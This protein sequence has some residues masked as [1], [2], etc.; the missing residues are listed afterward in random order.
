M[1][2]CLNISQEELKDYTDLDINLFEINRD[3]LQYGVLR[4][5]RA[6][7]YKLDLIND[8]TNDKYYEF[9]SQRDTFKDEAKSFDNRTAENWL[10]QLSKSMNVEAQVITEEV[11][12][13]IHADK[14]K[15]YSGENAFFADGI[16]YFIEGK[17]TPESVVHEFS[18]PIIKSLPKEIRDKLYNELLADGSFQD[19]ID[20]VNEMYQDAPESIQEEVLVRALT[21][22]VEMEELSPKLKNWF[23][24]LMY[25]IK[26]ILRKLLGRKVNVG[27]LQA[28]TTLKGLAEM[29]AKGDVLELQKEMITSS[30][31]IEYFKDKE[32]FIESFDTISP[33]NKKEMGI[34]FGT[35]GKIFSAVAEQ[36]A[37]ILNSEKAGDIML[38]LNGIFAD[39]LEFRYMQ[40]IEALKEKNPSLSKNE[41]IEYFSKKDDGTF[42]ELNDV[43]HERMGNMMHALYK[44]N[45]ILTEGNKK[46]KAIDKLNSREKLDR[47]IYFKRHMLN[48]QEVI[49]DF[50]RIGS[51]EEAYVI[52]DGK[53]KL[54]AQGEPIR[55]PVSKLSQDLK[56]NLTEMQ[57]EIAR[58]Q[59]ESV[60]DIFV[61][62]TAP[63]AKDALD[64]F[65]AEMDGPK[66]GAPQKIRDA[67]YKRF[68]SMTE[69]EYKQYKEL[70]AKG[71][72]SD[73]YNRLH[74]LWLTGL[75]F[76]ESKADAI[77]DG[78]AQDANWSN[79]FLES[80]S[81]NT[82]PAIESVYKHIQMMTNM[83][84]TNAQSWMANFITVV[85]PNIH[86]FSGQKRGGIGLKQSFRDRIATI[87]NGAI[88]EREEI[89]FLN[90][91][92]N[93]RY[94]QT[95][96][97]HKIEEAKKAFDADG[98]DASKKLW[99]EAKHDYQKWKNVYMNQDFDAGYYAANDL[100]MKDDIGYEA[101]ERR[102]AIFDEM[103]KLQEDNSDG[104]HNEIIDGLKHDLKQ[105][106][107]TTDLFGNKKTGMDLAV[108]ERL[109]EYTQA[110]A[111]YFI[112]DEIPGAFQDAYDEYSEYVIANGSKMGEPAYNEKM[113]E[114]LDRNTRT[115]L[116]NSVYT[117]REKLIAEKEELLKLLNEE[118]K[119]IFDDTQEQ[120]LIN[121]QSNQ[122][123]D[124]GNQPDG[125]EATAKSR[126]AVLDA[127]IEVEKKRQDMITRS[128]LSKANKARF[129]ELRQIYNDDG[130]VWKDNSNEQEYNKLVKEKTETSERLGLNSVT[131]AR[132]SEIDAILSQDNIPT[133]YYKNTI[134]TL[135][136][137][138]KLRTLFQEF[139]ENQGHEFTSMEEAY[140]NDFT[141]FVQSAQGQ[142]AVKTDD[143]FK[144]FVEQNHYEKDGVLTPTKL[145]L[146]NMSKNPYDYRTKRLMSPKDKDGNR[147][148]LDLIKIDDQYRI[149]SAEFFTRV[150]KEKYET[151]KVIGETVDNR[152]KWL[153]KEEPGNTY[154]NEK[155]Y[156]LKENDPKTFEFMENV[157]REYIKG[158]EVGE[159]NDKMW[160]TFPRTRKTR[161][162][163][164]VT[165]NVMKFTRRTREAFM[166]AED[167]VFDYKGN[168]ET[169]DELKQ[170]SEHLKSYSLINTGVKMPVIG[171][172]EN[173]RGE[174]MHIDDVS[175]D[176][177]KTIPEYIASL[178]HKK[179][180]KEANSYARMMQDEVGKVEIDKR[181]FITQ[182]KSNRK[183]DSNYD[184]LDESYVKH[185][186]KEG[187]SKRD[188]IL[189][190]LI[191]RDLD[192]ITLTGT[193]SQARLVHRAL[194]SMVK[195][196]SKMNFNWNLSSG[197]INFGQMKITSL[198]HVLAGQEMSYKNYVLGEKWATQTA[199]KV[200]R[201]IR[202]KGHK[203]LDEQIFTLFDAISGRAMETM[204]DQL[205]RTYIGDVLDNK[206]P[207]KVRKWLEM[208]GALQNFGGMM[209][210]KKVKITDSAGNTKEIPY[211]K[212]FELVDGR[213]QTKEGVEENYAVTYDKDGNP[214][215]GEGFTEQKL[216]MQNVIMKWN[217]AFAKKD[218]ALVGRWVIAKQLLFL[219]KHVI[220]IA[221]KQFSFGL[222]MSR[223][224]WLPSM[225]KRMNWS[226]GEAEW[227]HWVGTA[228]V[229]R[230]F[231]A[232]AAKGQN[233]LMYLSKS[234]LKGM[235]YVAFQ[236]LIGY[237][238][239]S[240]WRLLTPHFTDDDGIEKTDFMAMHDRSGWY[241]EGL[242]G[243]YDQDGDPETQEG[244]GLYADQDYHDF[245]FKGFML[246]H[247]SMVTA[248]LNDEYN[249]VNWL[250]SWSGVKD[251][252]G[253]TTSQSIALSQVFDYGT[254]LIDM[255]S[256]ESPTS[257]SQ[258][259]GPYFFEQPDYKYES[260]FG[261]IGGNY[262]RWM[263]RFHGFNNK[264]L[265]PTGA[266]ERFEAGKRMR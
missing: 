79:G 194:D 251:V 247:L 170:D 136:N 83:Y 246:N 94:D 237:L 142:E 93:Y 77:L 74:E 164:V 128:G 242:F 230:D 139:I 224:S 257:P 31:V 52:E 68:H 19:I 22:L 147:K 185:K 51:R 78:S 100:L 245:H 181:N 55:N 148:K 219:K 134:I 192:G 227:G 84:E 54:D 85:S 43:I 166:G 221:S 80:L 167:D 231:F 65:N 116:K 265:N 225:R 202:R 137:T 122:V 159:N 49:N 9:N 40:E 208:Q 46:V 103:N 156:Q 27:K 162:E 138:P 104:R 28:D 151:K 203:S 120:T 96:H 115:V 14:Q 168:D 112:E 238:L 233:S 89:V 158:Q 130:G 23:D 121:E 177:L 11:A 59:K 101:G 90:P 29:V 205:S 30:D 176:F 183:Q 174:R 204:G 102:E 61:E 98:T 195:R 210:E 261:D 260:P 239:K 149:P 33:N 2:S 82:D 60:R 67:A 91:W 37:D 39:E 113:A 173:A 232:S 182:Q 97:K 45:D 235:G 141:A 187:R 145:W 124:N 190:A 76:D 117:Q 241:D 63:M 129:D 263:F 186:R 36:K 20:D 264:M 150:V 146:V 32:K 3:F 38:S 42:T 160:L 223:H 12:E 244:L 201:D 220:P 133:D 88:V 87:E 226:T 206:N 48:Y 50:N 248:K 5:P 34:M 15:K 252:I 35:M 8:E 152:G 175:T 255:M 26:Q 73:D 189:E 218:Q 92:K 7:R 198:T 258:V 193:G 106:R 155:Y 105:L 254:S 179:G 47:L 214:S 125:N 215:L 144:K 171:V 131:L 110:R 95:V 169:R 240:L 114:W 262:F 228:M 212:A 243:A 249:S 132:L 143:N 266:E 10:F 211:I 154:R 163:N 209:Y 24:K 200:S 178:N 236:L 111:E 107:S 188:K 161:L 1:S 57:N 53:L 217:G 4:S 199:F 70:K 191:E 75:E 13:K 127:H 153:P 18:H 126:K 256:G 207:Q 6:I 86:I 64:K 21:R 72:K 157:K 229:L 250:G 25:Q 135:L 253:Q 184:N 196:S 172:S 119:K 81:N 140:N 197:V 66:K 222:G 234:E 58:I 56:N 180:L 16:V 123:K 69:A 44:V 62:L 165:G 216:H 109:Q 17:L 213:I 259:G 71:I 108:A 41:I 118:N 99:K